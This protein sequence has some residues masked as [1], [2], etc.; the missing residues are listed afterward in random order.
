MGRNGGCL[1]PPPLNLEAAL[2][3][4][5]SG[6]GQQTSTGFICC[7]KRAVQENLG[8][9]DHCQVHEAPYVAEPYTLL[10]A[11]QSRSRGKQRLCSRD[12][13]SAR[14]STMPGPVLDAA[15]TAGHPAAAGPVWFME[16]NAD[17]PGTPEPSLD[18]FGPRGAA[19]PPPLIGRQ[20]RSTSSDRTWSQHSDSAAS[21]APHSPAPAAGLATPSG[22]EEAPVHCRVP[23]VRQPSSASSDSQYSSGMRAVTHALRDYA[24]AWSD[25]VDEPLNMAPGITAPWRPATRCWGPM[26]WADGVDGVFGKQTT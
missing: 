5:P 1:R 12:L 11:P 7:S 22:A 17:N 19:A 15:P 10:A 14:G 4:A 20:S 9:S 8:K 2:P 25:C 23:V 13:D 26:T 6:M 18:N 21:S 24:F 16:P 3:R